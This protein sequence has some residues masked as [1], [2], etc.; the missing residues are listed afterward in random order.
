MPS[1]TGTKRSI[2]LIDNYKKSKDLKEFIENYA[3]ENIKIEELP[4][5]FVSEHL[6]TNAD[7]PMGKFISDRLMKLDLKGEFEKTQAESFES[8]AKS[9]REQAYELNPDLKPKRGRPP[10]AKK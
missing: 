10:K 5:E 7:T 9:L 3:K 4:F 1:L 6:S 2:E 8:E